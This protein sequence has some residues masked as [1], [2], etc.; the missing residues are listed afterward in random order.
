MNILPI[1]VRELRGE[2]R[3]PINYWLRTFGATVLTI[4]FAVFLSNQ[5]DVKSGGDA[6]SALGFL[7]FLGIWV[8][9]PVLSADCISREK[10]EGTLGLLF[11]TPLKPIEII[12]SKGS[13]HAMRSLT[14]IIAAVPVLAI[15][16]VLGGI[17]TTDLLCS[18]VLDL[19]ALCFALAAGLLASSLASQWMRAVILAE[20]FSAVFAFV[21]FE[22][23]LFFLFGAG[24]GG[25]TFLEDL[26]NEAQL[27]FY[28]S[29]MQAVGSG[30]PSLNQI[31]TTAS[32]LFA[33]SVLIFI[34]VMFFAAFQ[35]KKNW[36]E[37]PPSSRRLWFQ[38]IFCTP[39]IW[40]GLLRRQ[41]QARL[42]R[43]PVGWLE[44]YSWS[45]R[46]SKWGWCFVIVV[47][48][49]WLLTMN[50]R[51]LHYGFS[52]LTT[53]VLV[54]MAFSAVGSFQKEKQNGALELLLVTPLREKDIIVGRLWGIWAQFLPAFALLLLTGLLL[55]DSDE[56]GPGPFGGNFLPP[57][58]DFIFVPIVGLYFAMRLKYFLA[59]WLLTAGLA[60]F[61]PS[62]LNGLARIGLGGFVATLT[63]ILLYFDLKKRTCVVTPIINSKLS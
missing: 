22:L 18:L 52:W 9:V 21:V 19:T 46:L 44:Q 3:R 25:Q 20:I 4:I 39:R 49:S 27:F 8:V 2:A 7:V 58:F 36:Q 31:L 62:F 53:A 32:S 50:A 14:L 13:I 35:I 37:N 1:V 51:M 12:L 57:I 38:K 16:F 40:I 34:A 60:L 59:A 6:F 54:S 28:N 30:T 11:L 55:P 17:T 23:A 43:N 47:I 48:G 63:A 26:W 42:S 33:I 29:R 56:H 61:L 24:L 41:N 10:R 5:D 15:P 45:A